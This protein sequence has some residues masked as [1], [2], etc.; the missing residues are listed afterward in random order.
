MNILKTL[1]V[2]AF[3]CFG[4]D[5]CQNSAAQSDKSNLKPEVE[6]SSPIKKADVET[7]EAK[8]VRIAEEFVKKN[9]YTNFPADKENLSHETVEFYDN[10]EELLNERHNTLEPNAYGLIK[11]GRGNEK[12]WTVVFRY[13]KA[14][15]KGL[16]EKEYNSLGR[17]VTMNENFENLLVEHK[18]IFIK[19]VEKKLIN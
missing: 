2:C 12:G 17:A 11:H 14:G 15:I 9:G 13:N 10:I 6:N 8:A 7:P 19:F 1:F 4:L 16:S 5:A 18:D 3:F